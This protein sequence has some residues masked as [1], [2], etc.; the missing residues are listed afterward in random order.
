MD[1][2]IRS[3]DK[4]VLAKVYDLRVDIHC[5]DKWIIQ[6]NLDK[7]GEYYVAGIYKNQERALEVLDEINS[8][9]QT[10]TGFDIYSKLGGFANDFNN[11]Y[12]LVPV[13]QMPEV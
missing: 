7:R 8:C 5:G 10:N 11:K 6:A 9:I 1:L 12:N 4:T 3:Q 13:Y 2:W